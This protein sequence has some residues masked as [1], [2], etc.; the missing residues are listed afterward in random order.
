LEPRIFAEATDFYGLSAPIRSIREN[1]RFLS[2]AE[3]MINARQ[4][5]NSTLAPSPAANGLLALALRGA[6]AVVSP[7]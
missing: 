2:V 5:G 3:T 7:C 4:R 6:L 1:P